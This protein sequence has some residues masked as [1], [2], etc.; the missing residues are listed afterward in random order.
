MIVEVDAW[1]RKWQGALPQVAHEELIGI[2]VAE[3]EEKLP[4]TAR[5][6]EVLNFI[7]FTIATQGY[8]PSFTEIAACFKFRSLATVH[9]HLTRLTQKGWIERPEFGVPRSIRVLP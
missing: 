8:A 4:L 3:S 2:L 1:R 9:E 6:R 7:T 5:Q